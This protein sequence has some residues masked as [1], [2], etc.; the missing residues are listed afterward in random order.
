MAP[1]SSV[2]CHIQNELSSPVLHSDSDDD[3][4][5]S[6]FERSDIHRIYRWK[7]KSRGFAAKVGAGVGFVLG[8]LIGGA[9]ESRIENAP[10]HVNSDNDEVPYFAGMLLGTIGGAGP[11]ALIGG[12]RKGKLLYESK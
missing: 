10:G 3:G 6:S 8:G 5:L 11:G 9:T 2:N 4:N 12:K 1:S 7:G